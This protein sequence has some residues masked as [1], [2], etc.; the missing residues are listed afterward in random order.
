MQVLREIFSG[1]DDTFSARRSEFSGLLV[2]QTSDAR[3]SVEHLSQTLEEKPW[4]NDLVK[5]AVPID[6]VVDLD[7]GEIVEAAEILCQKAPG[8]EETFRVRIRKRGAQ[9]DRMDLVEK[10]ADL[11]RNPVNLTEPDFELR[12][13]MLRKVAGVSLIKR[14][15]IFPDL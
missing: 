7:L 13:E 9:I 3:A 14:G 5:R 2:A 6:I 1:F 8:E 4:Y 12:V 15:E 11:F 10:I